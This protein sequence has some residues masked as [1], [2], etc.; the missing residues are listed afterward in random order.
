MEA[1][2]VN[3]CKK[4]S[5][6]TRSMAHELR[7]SHAFLGVVVGPNLLKPTVAVFWK[8][9]RPAVNIYIRHFDG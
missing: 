9:A 8:Q 6:P 1:V 2:K 5:S 7:S 4:W 3:K